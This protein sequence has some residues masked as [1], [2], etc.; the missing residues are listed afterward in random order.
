M[1]PYMETQGIVA[2]LIFFMSSHEIP[3]PTPT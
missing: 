1:E 2:T 3:N